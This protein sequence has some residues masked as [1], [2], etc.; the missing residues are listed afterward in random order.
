SNLSFVL[1][2]CGLA[3]EELN[4]K[5]N[6][7]PKV[8]RMISKIASFKSVYNF[9]LFML[10]MIFISLFA[11]IK[12]FTVKDF[13]STINRLNANFKNISEQNQQVETFNRYKN[14][15]NRKK[16]VLNTLIGT[17]PLWHGVLKEISHIVP[18]NVYLEKISF[19]Y[20]K[21]TK[22]INV[23]ISGE[24]YR[25]KK[26]VDFTVSQLS[27]DMKNSSY[28]T[29]VNLENINTK[30]KRGSTQTLFSINAELLY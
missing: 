17:R 6:L 27:L 1:P 12:F 30:Y 23:N 5:I 8:T 10:Y 29:K 28:F 20:E 25:G 3:L 16:K 11:Y 15:V 18:D 26:S 13:E 9:A 19:E 21:E 7:V 22:I 14:K 4:A 2:S 24:I